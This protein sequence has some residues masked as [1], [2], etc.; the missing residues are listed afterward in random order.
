[1]HVLTAVSNELLPHF[2]ATLVTRDVNVP[3]DS[4]YRPLSSRK[5]DP[6]IRETFWPMFFYKYLIAA[7]QGKD[8]VPQT[9]ESLQWLKVE[10]LS[11]NVK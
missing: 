2:T 1:M 11:E 8:F 5:F 10:N 9:L 7:L 6:T 3:R 4:N